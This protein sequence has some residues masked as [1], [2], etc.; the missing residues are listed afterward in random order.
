M[1]HMGSEPTYLTTWSTYTTTRSTDHPK[2]PKK[3]MGQQFSRVGND[4]LR[5]TQNTTETQSLTVNA[6][7]KPTS[8][9]L[10]AAKKDKSEYADLEGYL[11]AA[12]MQFCGEAPERIFRSS[13]RFP[14]P[15]LRKGVLNRI[16]MY[17]GSFNP[18]HMGHKLLLTHAFFRSNMENV[19]AAIV[20]PN[21]SEWI[22]KKL[23]NEPDA[24]ILSREERARLW[25]DDQ[26]T[27][28]SWV[29]PYKNQSDGDFENALLRI[30]QANG[31]DIEFAL[32]VGGDHIEQAASNNNDDEDSLEPI[33]IFS[34]GLRSVPRA[35]NGSLLTFAGYGEWQVTQA[36]DIR[37]FTSLASRK[38]SAT[39]V[40]GLLYPR[41]GNMITEHSWILRNKDARAL[42]AL[43][44]CLRASGYTKVC[45]NLQDANVQVH[46]VPARNAAGGSDVSAT[47]IRAIIREVDFAQRVLALTNL[48]PDPQMLSSL[49]DEKMKE[50]L[51]DVKQA[52]RRHR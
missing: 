40:L 29:N 50:V 33:V 19:V 20:S 36:P 28:W 11:H 26:L 18:P 39:A 48:V 16:L 24:L 22:R 42:V 9:R 45:V 6:A 15:Q 13:K 10:V 37:L 17:P 49:A 52:P 30:V 46:F 2:Q 1:F 43:Q 44:Q 3:K 27:P 5:S 35:P 32:V 41:A 23:H 25:D 7:P 47:H 34:D 4:S 51:K 12:L 31:F 8:R 21:S 14:K 38:L